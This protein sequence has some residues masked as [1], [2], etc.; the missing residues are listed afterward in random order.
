MTVTSQNPIEVV[1]SF[2][3]FCYA[4]RP[5]SRYYIHLLT[6]FFNQGCIQTDAFFLSIAKIVMAMEAFNGN[7]TQINRRALVV[8]CLL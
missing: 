8:S 1:Q 2:I 7:A 3:V 6:C 5:I 4:W